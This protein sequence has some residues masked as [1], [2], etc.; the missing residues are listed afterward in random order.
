MDI[1]NLENSLRHLVDVPVR[2]L[3]EGDNRFRVFTPYTFNDGDHFSIVA[4]EE[5]GQW[6]F[7]DEGHT[8][9]HLSIFIPTERLIDSDLTQTIEDIKNTFGVLEE[10]GVLLAPFDEGNM[11]KVF[12]TYV[13]ALVK[14]SAIE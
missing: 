9:M 2:L 1:N 7:S 11:G 10:Q 5:N 13:Q 4:K 8:F 14:I 6:V 12:S 3:D